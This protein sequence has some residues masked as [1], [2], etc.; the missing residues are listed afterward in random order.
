M[1]PRIVR[2][3]REHVDHV[4]RVDLVHGDQLRTRCDR[5]DGAAPVFG[6]GGALVAGP[7]ADVQPRAHPLRDAA[8]PAEKAVRHADQARS[9]GLDAHNVRRI[10]KSSSAWV[11]TM[12]S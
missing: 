6:D 10:S 3:G 4:G 9:D 8:A 5:G 1:G 12:K 2:P 11:P 7:E